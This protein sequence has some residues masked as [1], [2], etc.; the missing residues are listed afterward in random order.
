MTD[1]I[2]YRPAVIDDALCLSILFQQV[3]IHTYGTEGVTWEY[4]NFITRKF[5]PDRLRQ[6]M[7]THPGNLMVATYKNNLIGV[8]ELELG[9]QSRAGDIIGPEVSKLYVL[10]HFCGKG[11]GTGLLHAAEQYVQ[12]G[13]ANKIWLEV[14][15]LNARAINFYKK[16]GYQFAGVALFEME[17]N[18]YEN[19]VMYKDL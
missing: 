15:T 3:Y 4:A 5:S 14:Y 6:T 18:T 8:L 12:S 7:I 17:E 19:F 9:K 13:G 10:E 16:R 11:V 1:H 2:A